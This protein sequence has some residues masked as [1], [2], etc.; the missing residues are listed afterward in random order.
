LVESIVVATRALPSARVYL[1]YAYGNSAEALVSGACTRTNNLS[2][3]SDDLYYIHALLKGVPEPRV[4][5]SVTRID[6]DL[7]KP[8]SAR[9]VPMEGVKVIIE[10][11]GR[12]FEAVTNKQGL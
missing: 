10:G 12:Q 9:V 5:G 7:T 11:A 8:N 1:I 6:N 2:Y 3:A 4:Y